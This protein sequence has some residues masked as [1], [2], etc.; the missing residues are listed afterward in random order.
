MRQALEA[1]HIELHEGKGVNLLNRRGEWGSN[2]SPQM[3]VENSK[4]EVQVRGLKRSPWV[5]E[6][7]V[8]KKR[9]R[10]SESEPTEEA[11]ST[12]LETIVR[13]T[14]LE[15]ENDI[16][17]GIENV[18]KR[19]NTGQDKES[20]AKKEVKNRFKKYSERK[21]RTSEKPKSEHLKSSQIVKI[22][23]ERSKLKLSNSPSNVCAPTPKIP[24]LCSL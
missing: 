16:E 17:Q 7:P 24:P 1:H 12:E 5:E 19:E 21:V 15:I 20:Q 11:V 8:S 2:L 22:L 18:S 4:C 23:K 3:V 6:K 10:I 13:E 9:Q 14:P